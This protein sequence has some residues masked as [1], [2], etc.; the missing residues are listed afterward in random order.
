LSVHQGEN[1]LILNSPILALEPI[2][3]ASLY[4]FMWLFLSIIHVTKNDESPTEKST[5]NIVEALK[6]LT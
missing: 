3:F 1:V 6:P 5:R 2:E 4:C